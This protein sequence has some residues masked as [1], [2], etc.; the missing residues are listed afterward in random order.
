MLPLPFHARPGLCSRPMSAPDPND[1]R[2]MAVY[3]RLLGYA[4]PHWKVLVL[5]FIAT[6][7]FAAVD[8]SF[9]ALVKPLLDQAFV[10]QNP[11]YIRWLPFAIVGLFL[12]RGVSS[13]ISAYG[14][15]WVARRVVMEVRGGLYDH[16]LR[17]PVR[18]F[19]QVS[20]G[21]VI[22]RLTYHVEQVADAVTG[23]LTTVLKDG[24][25]VIALIGW[26]LWLNWQLTL[27][28]FAVMPFIAVIIAYVSRRFRLISG[29]IQQSV[30]DVTDTAEET[31]GGQRV[32][33]LA[34]AEPAERRRFQGVNNRNRQLSMKVVATQAGSAAV[35]QFIA[36]WAVAAIVY[37][38]TQPAMLEV[39][40]P[41][42]FAS[43]ML[44]MLSLLQ[45]IKSMGKINERLQRGIA[46]GTEI[47][48]MMNEA[49]EPVG[50]DRPLARAHGEIRFDT[51]RFRYRSELEDALQGVS[52]TVMPGQTVA[53]V[54][55]SGSGK[56]TLLSLLP[57]FYDPTD[58]TVLLDGHDTREYRLTDL[59]A[60]IALVD[61]QVRLFN[62]SVADNIAYGLPQRPDRDAIEQAA[63]AANA[64]EFIERL[65]QG[66]DTVIGSD[67]QQLSGGQRQRIAIA[68]A[69]L[70]NA[71]ILILDEA[72]SA[73]DTESE[74][75]VQSALARLVEGRTTLVIAHRLSTVQSAD[76]IVVMQD[77]RI[78][79]TGRHEQLLARNGLYAALHQM[80]FEAHA[81][82]EA[83]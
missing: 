1:L 66:L 5:A 82:D 13:F 53:F 56:S 36:A 28:A 73:L 75:L 79:E 26:M 63:R 41:G 15:A 2:P 43:F 81:A 54:G 55:R 69:L 18:F 70:K 40:S 17:L 24:L 64:W 57:R 12:L 20:P 23:V 6:G 65:P 42:T 34:N 48:A 38:A 21:Q 9:A 44:A 8:A 35:I 39:M 51:V 37:F 49:P 74:R 33:K 67:G 78:I 7:V 61:Q 22:A 4:L 60:Q 3:R 25:T 11:T 14:M 31:V 77:G 62:A 19:D 27:F 52:F 16:L 46:A 59:R 50:G 30:S 72:T 32:I 45:P 83:A 10:A 80:Q 71:P 29:R 58:G 47:F 76:C 68:R